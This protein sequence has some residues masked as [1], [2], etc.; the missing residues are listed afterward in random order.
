[1]RHID[2]LLARFGADRVLGGMA[3]ISATLDADGR[4]ALLFPGA[5]LVFGELAGGFKRVHNGAI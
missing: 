2:E 1:M 3:Q 4:V 5:E